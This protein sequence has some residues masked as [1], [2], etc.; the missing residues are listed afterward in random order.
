MTED[1]LKHRIRNALILLADGHSFKV[2][3]LTFSSQNNN[4][5]T[6]KGWTNKNDLKSLNKEIALKE[7][8]ETK[9][10]FRKMISISSELDHFVNNKQIEYF[11]GYNYGMGGLE[12]CSE[13]NGKIKWITELQD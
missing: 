7:L 9:E 5:F 3:D 4:F 8:T 6:V 12:I 11:L 1:E 2:G 13:I 10:L